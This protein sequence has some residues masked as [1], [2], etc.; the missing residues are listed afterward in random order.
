MRHHKW[1]IA[2]IV[3]LLILYFPFAAAAGTFML[4]VRGWYV[5]WDSAVL[6]WFEQDLKADFAGAGRSMT[7]SKSSGTG[8]LA[9][10]LASYQTD[11]G[12]WSFSLAPMVFSAFNQDWDGRLS[13]MAMTSD[14]DLNRIDI[15]LAANYRLNKYMSVFFGYKYQDINIDLTLS[16]NTAMGDIT[17]DYKL[18]QKTHIPSAGM[19]FYYAVH[20]KIALGMQLGLLYSIPDIKMTDMDGTEYYVW[21]QPTIGF[22]GEFAVTYQPI[23]SL[24]IQLGYRYQFFRLDAIQQRTLQKTES[25]DISH[26]PTLTAVWVF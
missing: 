21:T 4:G 8:Y 15:D 20:E 6:D 25:N 24:I 17:N 14:V 18:E 16:Y 19:G 9:G 2:A 5:N 12:K 1:T 10:P 7:T 22:N 3:S 11:N 26:G 23:R 13:G